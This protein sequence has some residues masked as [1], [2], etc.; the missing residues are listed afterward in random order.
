MHSTYTLDFTANII[1]PVVRAELPVTSGRLFMAGWG[2]DM[3]KRGWAHYVRNLRASEMNGS[4]A[5]L[6]EVPDSAVWRLAD[7][8]ARTIQ[9][10]YQVDL[11]YAQSPW[12]SGNEQAATLQ[13]EELFT[14]SK[15]LF[16][17]SSTPGKRTVT[18]KIPIRWH[19]STPWAPLSESAQSFTVDDNN[20]LID[21]SL[22]VGPAAPAFTR[23]GRFTFLLATLGKAKSDRDRVA[24]ALGSVVREYLRVFPQT[25]PSRYLMTLFRAS[26]RDAEAY[27]ASAAFSEPDSLTSSNRILW[28]NT[29]AHELFH[30][31]NGHAIRAANYANLQWFSEGFTDYYATR[32][33]ARARVLNE[34]LFSRKL[35]HTI[36]LYL[37][38]KAAPA[39]DSVTLVSAGERKGRNRLG[40]YNGGW[41]SAFCM[42]TQIQTATRGT[43]SLDDVMRLLYSRFGLTGRP[44]SL[45]DLPAAFVDGSGVRFD[46]FLTRYVA[47]H[48]TI[49][50]AECL[51]RAGYRGGGAGYDGDYYVAPGTPGG[52]RQWLFGD[53]VK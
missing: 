34:S 22:V 50:V 19:V 35:E 24:S 44:L 37:Y 29:L 23:A 18:F 49:P 30:A 32:S 27:A 12:P 6:S 53:R 8:T 46:E 15:A 40:V 45:E 38:F 16:I 5:K 4:E 2:A 14:V 9:L 25:P 11:S 10:S 48:E 47:G 13:G 41:V 7:T 3:H 26:G 33:L 28:A 20:S 36:G 17:V 52:Y 39:F 31:W 21:N 51:Q 1:A 43:R 42:D